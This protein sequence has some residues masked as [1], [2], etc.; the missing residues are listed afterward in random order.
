M[1]LSMA[2]AIAA[3][4]LDA[5]RR[6]RLLQWTFA[7]VHHQHRA[8]LPML[9]LAMMMAAMAM[10]AIDFHGHRRLRFHVQHRRLLL[11][12]LM[13]ITVAVVEL[14][15]RVGNQLLRLFELFQ[16]RANVRER[17]QRWQ[18]VESEIVIVIEQ[19]CTVRWITVDIVI[20]IE[21]IQ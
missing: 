4:V 19:R 7:T 2:I 13:A 15:E 3:V 10:M 9:L 21:Q 1:L 5:I 8:L 16:Q 17:W 12:L 11:L 14:T 18:I 20:V 6:R